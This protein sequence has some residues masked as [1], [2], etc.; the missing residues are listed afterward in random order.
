MERYN[1]LA[2][3]KKWRA[4]KSANSVKNSKNTIIQK[5][6]EINNFTFRGQV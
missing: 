3:E 2:V 4:N 1:F 5:E 6:K